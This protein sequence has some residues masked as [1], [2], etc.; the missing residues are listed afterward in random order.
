MAE[1]QKN[2][3]G[4][5]A[6]AELYGVSVPVIHGMLERGEIAGRKAGRNWKIPRTELTRLEQELN[7]RGSGVTQ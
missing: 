3:V 7:S 2:T 5:S 4:T 1:K 6:I